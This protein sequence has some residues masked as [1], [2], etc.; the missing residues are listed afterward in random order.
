MA[1][2]RRKGRYGWEA[3]ERFPMPELAEYRGKI[4]DKGEPQLTISTHKDSRGNL[5]SCASVSWV[6][7][8]LETFAVFADF[9]V[10]PIREP[11]RCTEANVAQQQLRAVAMLDDLKAQALEFYRRKAGAA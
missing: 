8:S 6:H 5:S 10:W 1:G 11:A 7:E 4:H 9:M 3:R 2:Y